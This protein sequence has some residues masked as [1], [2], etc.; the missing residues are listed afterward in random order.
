MAVGLT[1]NGGHKPMCA[2][3]TLSDFFMHVHAPPYIRTPIVHTCMHPIA[4]PSLHWRCWRLSHLWYVIPHFTL[5]HG[6]S[7]PL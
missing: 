4:P 2:D 1:P 7:P 3:L 5:L 6:L